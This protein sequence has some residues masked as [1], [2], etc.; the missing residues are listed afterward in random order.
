MLHQ[1]GCMNL[2][3]D[4]F[5][6]FFSVEKADV[7]E[8]IRAGLLLISVNSVILE[9]RY[10]GIFYRM[11]SVMSAR[12]KLSDRSRATSVSIVGS[13]RGFLLRLFIVFTLCGLAHAYPD[14][15]DPTLDERCTAP[16][17]D[18]PVL[19]YQDFRWGYSAREM[20]ERFG[21][22]Y[23]S[24]KRLMDRARW[25]ESE[26]RYELTMKS[27]GKKVA[28][29]IT[30]RFIDSVRSHI[31]TALN[32][33]YVRHVFFPDMGHAHLLIDQTFYDEVIRHVPV[34][35]SHDVYVRVLDHPETRYLYH[36]AE[37]LKMLDEQH[38]VLADK[39]LGW[40]YYTRN[41]VG[42]NDDEGRIEIHRNLDSL[43][44]TVCKVNSQHRY[45]SS[46]F[47]VSASKDGCFSFRHR[48]EV[49]RFDISLRDLPAFY[50]GSDAVAVIAG[51]SV[52]HS[53]DR[54]AD[55]WGIHT[56]Q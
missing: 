32:L 25:N 19:G 34:G 2:E 43:G 9:R 47:H 11:V 31:E 22:I 50:D 12:G 56:C 13:L 10:R 23:H 55:P 39:Y 38:R 53:S 20:D 28:V 16:D 49:R 44:N 8:R 3:P 35:Q 26:A 37:Q 40:R 17:D 51:A 29:P 14:T 30:R 15:A 54:S 33:G 46:G 5:C 48:D 24:G 21:E 41:L 6:R 42:R 18:E 1:I 52:V 27:G 36:T 4:Q 45:W 7:V